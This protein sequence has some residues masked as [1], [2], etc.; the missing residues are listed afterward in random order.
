MTSGARYFTV[1]YSTFN[2]WLIIYT[3]KIFFMSVFINFYFI[4]LF[5]MCVCV[6]MLKAM[7]L[8]EPLL[9][10]HG[11]HVAKR[12]FPNSKSLDSQMVISFQSIYLCKQFFSKLNITKSYY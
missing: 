2:N 3:I 9:E 6:L 8:N 12:E 11:V 5:F 1:S 4:Y 7:Y 10:F